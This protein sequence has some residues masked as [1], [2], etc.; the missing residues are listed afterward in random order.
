MTLE[1]QVE[2]LRKTQQTQFKSINKLISLVGRHSD[3]IEEM[4]GAIMEMDELHTR[5]I[6]SIEKT[7]VVHNQT[8]ELVYKVVDEL[9]THI[10]EMKVRF[11]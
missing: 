10:E 5:R 6:E 11:N 9:K 8:F 4:R 7:L 1:E 3:D 2:D